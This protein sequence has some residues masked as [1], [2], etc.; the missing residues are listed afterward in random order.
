MAAEVSKIKYNEASEAIKLSHT[1]LTTFDSTIGRNRWLISSQFDLRNAS[2][3][4]RAKDGPLPLTWPRQK[5][6]RAIALQFAYLSRGSRTAPLGS[7]IWAP[8]SAACSS[9]SG[10]VPAS[11]PAIARESGR[12]R[13]PPTGRTSQ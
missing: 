1:G 6:Q 9:R 4:A 8:A 12:S 13:L 11:S 5:S 2:E 10:A 7:Q 3:A